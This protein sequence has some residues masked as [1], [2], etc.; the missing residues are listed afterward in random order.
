[1]AVRR[2]TCHTRLAAGFLEPGAC[3]GHV[4][5]FATRSKSAWV[6]PPLPPGCLHGPVSQSGLMF[7]RACAGGLALLLCAAQADPQAAQ[8]ERRTCRHHLHR[9]PVRFG[10][11][12]EPF[13]VR[14][15]GGG[16]ETDS[17]GH[18]GPA[19][20][21]GRMLPKSAANACSCIGRL[22]RCVPSSRKC[23]VQCCVVWWLFERVIWLLYRI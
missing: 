7:C 21:C 19:P 18:S 9:A 1:M 20:P 13:S 6:W 11:I 8:E 10:N 17:K 5:C 15:G 16:R 12:P 14:H 3:A 4:C 23:A 2:T 22:V